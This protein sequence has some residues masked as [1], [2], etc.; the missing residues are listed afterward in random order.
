MM[1]LLPGLFAICLLTPTLAGAAAADLF[2]FVLPWDDA[3]PSATDVSAWN[4]KPAGKQGFISVKDGHLS[5]GEKRF[6]IF[7]VNFA[8][9]ANFPGKE[10]AEKIA[11]RM[12]KFGINCV[13][14]HHMDNQ[15]APGGIWAKD[16]RTLDPGQLEKLDWFI[17][18]LKEHGIY[19]DLNLHVSRNYPDRPEGEKKGN[20][21]YDKGVDNFDAT[22][23]EEQKEYARMLLSHVNPYT[24]HSYLEEPAVALIEINNE[25]ALLFEWW[26]GG[27]DKIAAPYRGELGR[28]WTEWLKHAYGTNELLSAAWQTGARDG[29]PELLK[30]GDFAR[31]LSEW[32]LEKHEGAEATA[33][34]V[35]GALSVDVT[36]AGTEPWHVQIGQG[37]L[38]LQQ[39]QSYTVTFRAKAEA[40]H[41]VRISAGEAHA[42]WGVFES[43]PVKV[44][45]EWQSF[46]F[47]FVAKQDDDNARISFT[48]LGAQTGSYQFS[49][50]HVTASKVEGSVVRDASGSIAAFTR[51]EYANR[52]KAA[53][54]DWYRF[55]WSLEEKYWPGMYA[56]L[57]EELKARPLILGTQLFWSPFPIQAQLDLFD[58]HAYWQHPNFPH[59][60]WDMNDWTVKNVP[61]AGAPDGG[62]LP[63]LAQQRVIGK[64]YICTEY[65][66]P[67]P[68][69]Y[70]AE[71]FPLICAYAAA[72]DW[73]GIFAF[74][75]SHRSNDWAKGYFP[76][77]F[78]ID[79]HPVKM[80]T[81]PGAL[82]TWLR[83]DLPPFPASRVPGVTWEMAFDQARRGGP[84]IGAERFGVTT[85]DALT[86]RIGIE[87]D[88]R[89][90][91][92]QPLLREKADASPPQFIWDSAN[93][94][95]TID[96]ARSKAV[97][98]H[99]GGRTFQLGDVA[100]VPGAAHQDW[101]VIQVTVLE[102]ADFQSAR[103]MLVTAT[104]YA[105][106]TE[107]KWRDAAKTSVGRDW[108]H[109]PSLVE[110]IAATVK[111]PATTRLRAWALD[112]RG[113][114]RAEIP[115]KDGAL[116]IG[117]ESQTLWYELAA[118]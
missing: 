94:C 58:S 47:S 101:A 102:G 97:I 104:G 99:L 17:A 76:S 79:Q 10:D 75:Y 3:T 22:M 39:G 81:L 86:K 90:G 45:S 24:G 69:T 13:R 16:M 95:V 53:Q 31:G 20:P 72:Q 100:I 71:T 34:P 98:G 2:P 113:Q 6:R 52:T 7:G 67:A 64:P 40:G 112:E 84:R 88:R 19:A 32:N 35:A 85:M 12:A 117:P 77:F 74:A 55:L 42:P 65:S 33:T 70:S 59:A 25:N 29:G 41:S 91:I 63:R 49:D 82:A 27:L 73:D 68:N 43:K 118:E 57:R 28:L 109:A 11:A 60:Q 56:Y 89:A 106:N 116:T 61:M 96:T 107:M 46:A 50:V 83:G 114:R 54:H 111:L 36:K 78:D 14:F 62:T 115:V 37:R 30:N 1:K 26:T 21:S 108:G 15:A 44:T 8:F 23:I 66:H 38:N 87:F 18:K 5:A 110:G 93:G 9:G 51:D 48:D 92:T 105:E 103:R 4:E 80:A